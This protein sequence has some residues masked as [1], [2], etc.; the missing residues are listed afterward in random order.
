MAT[1]GN[2]ISSPAD[3]RTAA[4]KSRAS[5]AEPLELPSGATIL[6][7][8]PEPLEWIMSGRLPQRL[9][10]AALG[11]SQSH[12]RATAPGH[13]GESSPGHPRESGPGHPRESGDPAL[14]SRLRG[15]D[16]KGARGNDE[17]GARG[18]DEKGAHG[19]GGVDAGAGMTRE[20][21][22]ELARF[23]AQLVRASVVQPAIGDGPDDIPFDDIPVEDRAFIFQWACRALS[24]ENSTQE[25]LPS[26]STDGL[27]RF[28]EK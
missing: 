28:C 4:R 17:K 26:P 18:N 25:G 5:R 10:A 16:E 14:D 27:E 24:G 7:A 9:L 19:N 1:N 8:R 23:A 12:P 15:N 3:W 21:V 11:E 22:L 13:A 6:A 20:D 2:S